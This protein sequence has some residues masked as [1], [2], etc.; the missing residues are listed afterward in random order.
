M[1]QARTAQEKS[2]AISVNELTLQIKSSLESR[3]ADVWVSGEISN[4]RGP[5]SSGHIYTALKDPHSQI[6]MVIWRGTSQKLRVP[7]WM[8]EGTE[9]EVR[10]KVEVYAP[11]GNYQLI[12]NQISPKGEGALQAAFREMC[13]RLRSEGLFEERHKKPLPQF[14]RKIGIVTAPTG[15]AVR[16]MLRILKRRDPR[17]S[18]LIYPARVQ[19]EG[20]AE[21]VAAGIAWLNRH[22]EALEL[23]ALIVGRGGGS[24]EDLWAFNEEVVARAI[25]ASKLPVVSAVGH[26]IDTTVADFVADVRA[27]TPSEAAEMIVPELAWI[28]QQVRGMSDRLQELIGWQIEE[29]RG[30]LENLKHR[31]EARSPMRVLQQEVQRLDFM[32]ER[33]VGVMRNRLQSA[34]DQLAS[35]GSRL[36]GLSPLRVLAR[37]YAVARN[38]QG[39][40]LKSIT[41]VA[42]GD[43]I[44]VRLP[45]GE[46][47]AH[48]HE[49]ERKQNALESGE[50]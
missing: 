34:R 16:D 33:L 47:H 39:A 3:F 23:D 19:G 20:A 49:I 28:E 36:E 44:R 8:K 35:M 6:P 24:L 50:A 43:A 40:V 37:G 10:G 21:Q 45:D 42:T 2:N 11:R 27:A 31:L 13:D 30:E 5:H 26:E 32:E 48:V 17:L 38:N 14:P 41:D 9:V 4:Y 12:V 22:A 46:V 1:P 18:A 7:A 25:F 15:A 29:R